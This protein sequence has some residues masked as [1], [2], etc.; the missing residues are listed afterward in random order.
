VGGLAYDELRFGVV[1]TSMGADGSAATEQTLVD[2][3]TRGRHV[4]P[5]RAGPQDVFV[6]LP[7]SI[8]GARVTCEGIA[9]LRGAHVGSDEETTVVERRRMKDITLE[10]REDPDAGAGAADAGTGS[11]GNGAAGGS[12]GVTGTGGS[13]GGMGGSG[14]GTGG[15]G[16]MGGMAGIGGMAGTGGAAGMGGMPGAGGTGGKPLPPKNRDN[17]DPCSDKV[18]CRSDHC[19][20]GVCCESACDKECDACALPGTEGL[21]RKVAAGTPDPRARCEDK[22]PAICQ[23][24]G[25]CDITGRCANYAMGT[26]CASAT[27]E[28]GGALAVAAR[29]CDGSGK[30]TDPVKTE[31]VSPASCRAGVC[32]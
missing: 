30:C 27:C 28:N 29:T 7:S 16:A 8:A 12:G 18:E 32:Q 13:P 10:L 9:L 14:A 6:H 31:C 22:G 19:A 11:D 4:G 2:P 5:F 17:G 15:V 20:D 24:N 26:P 1:V 3:A 25:R 21:C 23:T